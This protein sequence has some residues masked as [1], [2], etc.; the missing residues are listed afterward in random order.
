MSVSRLVQLLCWYVNGELQT[1]RKLTRVVVPTVQGEQWTWCLLYFD[2]L[3]ASDPIPQL[4]PINLTKGEMFGLSGADTYYSAVEDFNCVQMPRDT[5]SEP[6]VQETMSAF[7]RN[8][9]AD[10]NPNPTFIFLRLKPELQPLDADSVA[11][12]LRKLTWLRFR[13]LPPGLDQRKVEVEI[14][15]HRITVEPTLAPPN[16]RFEVMES[17][18][19]GYVLPDMRGGIRFNVCVKDGH[20]QTFTLTPEVFLELIKFPIQECYGYVY[21]LPLEFDALLKACNNVERT[22]Q[23]SLKQ[24]PQTARDKLFEMVRN[25]IVRTKQEYMTRLDARKQALAKRRRVYLGQRWLGYVPTNENEVLILASKLETDLARNLAEFLI[26]EHTSQID[27]DGIVRIRRNSGLNL[28]ETATVE[29]EF[30]LENFF[31]HRHPFAITNYIICWTIGALQDG[32]HHFGHKGLNPQGPLSVQV[33]SVGWIRVL[34]FPEHMI[35]VLPL[36][37]FP[38]LSIAP[39]SPP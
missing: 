12:E 8:C 10:T 31:K 18:F 22:V 11:A 29:F 2:Q 20:L 1:G 26:L 25:Q 15:A 21:S 34:T 38:G 5:L 14:G 35:Y 30:S 3:A 27:I 36:E 37:H 9:L 19:A 4:P 39:V 16:L 7:V 17:Y 13:S 24:M 6:D 32:T 23:D 28:E 33:S